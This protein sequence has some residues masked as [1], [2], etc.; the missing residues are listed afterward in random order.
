MLFS[1]QP[2]HYPHN[3]V[4]YCI[5][6]PKTCKIFF[7]LTYLP[8]LPQIVMPCHSHRIFLHQ[9]F[10]A[11]QT[12]ECRYP[13]PGFSPILLLNYSPVLQSPRKAE[14]VCITYHNFPLFSVSFLQKKDTF[15]IHF[16]MFFSE[17]SSFFIRSCPAEALAKADPVIY[18]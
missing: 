18:A 15:S 14:M 1:R 9:N 6:I 5:L 7:L 13:R 11:A 17:F 10:L 4:Y 3:A 16:D 12:S 2:I 8:I